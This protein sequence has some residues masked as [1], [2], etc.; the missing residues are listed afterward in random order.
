M[1]MVVTGQ[2]RA[3]LQPTKLKHGP[4]LSWGDLFVLAGNAAI[5]SMGGQVR[6][7]SPPRQ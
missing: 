3:L 1:K 6:L 7:L 4:G 2:A 5:L